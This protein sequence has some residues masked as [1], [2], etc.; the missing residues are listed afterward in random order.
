M[1]V[2]TVSVSA[3]ALKVTG[4]FAT[5][6]VP[7]FPSVTVTSPMLTTV[8][9]SLV[10]VPVPVVAEGSIVPFVVLVIVTSNSSSDSTT[11]SPFTVT[12]NTAL[13]SPAGI[14]TVNSVG[15]T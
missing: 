15:A 7:S 5:T 11:S 9:S 14:V 8:A 10:I 3:G 12:G 13:V 1:K 6:V 2:T 4:K